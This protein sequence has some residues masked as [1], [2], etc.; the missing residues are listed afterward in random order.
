MF[1]SNSQTQ[2]SGVYNTDGCWITGQTYT[3]SM[4][5][6]LQERNVSLQKLKK[7]QIT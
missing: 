6:E 7:Q 1:T 4:L 5:T 3:C 2:V